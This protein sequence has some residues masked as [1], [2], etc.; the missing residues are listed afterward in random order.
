MARR[1]LI[2]IPGIMGSSLSYS[3]T[4]SANVKETYAWSEWIYES[5]SLLTQNP[6]LLKYNP[7]ANLTPQA[8]IKH[9]RLP[10]N[11]WSIDVY[12]SIDKRLAELDDY[13]YF[14]FP[15][16]WRRDI[17][18]SAKQLGKF[19]NET[20]GIGADANAKQAPANDLKFTL[21]C[22]SMGGL[23][24]GN[25]LVNG[26]INPNNVEQYITIGTPYLGSPGA[27]M[28]LFYSAYLAPTRIFMLALN[29]RRNRRTCKQNLL[30]CHRSFTSIFQ[31]LPRETLKYISLDGDLDLSNPL[32]KEFE[33]IMGSA[34]VQ[35]A[36]Q[37]HS[38]IDN[39]PAVLK[40]NPGIRSLFIYGNG[41]ETYFQFS[42][43][44]TPNG[45]LFH[46]IRSRRADDGDETVPARL[47]T[48]NGAD[49]R[50]AAVASAKHMTMCADRRIIEQVFSVL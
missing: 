41:I 40:S 21:V 32:S 2:F 17:G 9:L 34:K 37:I 45:K 23:V 30:E 43:K 49:L 8:L 47:A 18:D 13:E 19:C 28:S 12:G 1:I 31:L 36:I 38:E 48:F 15:Y 33:Q 6:G 22:H 50:D 25:A 35:R 16:D 44:I 29:L 14:P 4:T 24:A 46:D 26:Y 27:F 7:N 10:R 20:F 5:F 11:I 42:A 3:N 39:L